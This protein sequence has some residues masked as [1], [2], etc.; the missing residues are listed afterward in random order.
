M[1]SS[2]AKQLVVCHPKIFCVF[3]SK[4]TKAI[5]LFSPLL[6]SSTG[7]LNSLNFRFFTSENGLPNYPSHKSNSSKDVSTNGYD[8]GDK[9]L[10]EQIDRFFKG[11]D[12]A[13]PSIFESILKRKLRGTGDDSD[14]ELLKVLPD[15]PKH[16][17][18]ESDKEFDS[19]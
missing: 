16:N 8:V 11:E 15:Q 10:K 18:A 12:E 17:D 2:F 9:E 3:T 14:D 6:F 19:D 7:L 4:P 5:N 1:K 13:I